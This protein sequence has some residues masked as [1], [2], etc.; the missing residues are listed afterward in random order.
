MS[1]YV[2]RQE[3]HE[4]L[5]ML[6]AVFAPPEKPEVVEEAVNPPKQRKRDAWPI[7]QAFPSGGLAT[8]ATTRRIFYLRLQHRHGAKTT[9]VL[10]TG[11]LA[12]GWGSTNTSKAITEAI[13]AP[14]VAQK[15]SEYRALDSAAQSLYQTG[16]WTQT[17]IGV[18]LALLTPSLGLDAFQ[19]DPIV[20]R[21]IRSFTGPAGGNQ[22]KNG[23]LVR[24]FI[25]FLAHFSLSEDDIVAAVKHWTELEES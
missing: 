22:P 4:W 17:A 15:I 9:E 25:K 21:Y 6:A 1:E 13:V 8:Q 20:R 24:E 5:T 16:G 10:E 2:T 3:M 7:F 14:V 12:P 18:G 23:A 11:L 19:N